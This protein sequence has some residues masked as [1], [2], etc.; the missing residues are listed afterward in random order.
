MLT[1]WNDRRSRKIAI[2]A[3]RSCKQSGIRKIRVCAYTPWVRPQ[4]R[5]AARIHATRGS[6]VKHRRKFEI[7]RRDLLRV[8]AAG[9]AAASTS[10]STPAHAAGFPDKRKARYQADSS[11]VQNFYRVNRYPA[12]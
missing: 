7:G 11:N 10:V 9:A 8:L 6:S 4:A 12:K 3:A 2:P 1:V 5:G